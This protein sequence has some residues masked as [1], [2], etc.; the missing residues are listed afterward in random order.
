MEGGDRFP[1]GVASRISH[2][3]TRNNRQGSYTYRSGKKLDVSLLAKKEVLGES[4]KLRQID[5]FL[6]PTMI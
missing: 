5:I 1:C 2:T 6:T 3:N 4:R